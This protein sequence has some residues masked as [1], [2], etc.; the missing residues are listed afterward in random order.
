MAIAQ[1]GYI[2]HRQKLAERLTE[3][4]LGNDVMSSGG[5]S[6]LFMSAARR[7]GKSTFLKND[8]MPT[9]EGAGAV[10]VYVDLWTDRT[11]DPDDLIAAAIGEAMEKQAGLL[12]RVV[13][14]AT[15]TKKV[16]AQG[17][18]FGFKVDFGFERD[19][20]GKPGGTTLAKAFQAL[21]AK[22]KKQIVFII[23]EAQHALTTE[24][25]SDALFALKAA[26]DALNLTADK[27]QLAILATGSLRGKLMDLTRRKTQAFYGALVQDF[28]TLDDDYLQHLIKLKLGH[29]LAPEALPGP[30]ALMEAFTLVGKRPEEMEKVIALA[31]T[32]PQQDLG[33]AMQTVARLRRSELINDLRQQISGLSPLQRAILRLMF[34]RGEDFEAFTKASLAEYERMTDGQVTESQVQRALAWLVKEGLIWR[35]ARGA[36][37]VD[38]QMV[39]EYFYD[40]HVDEVLKDFDDLPPQL[41]EA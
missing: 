10:A 12:Q 36:Y 39:S 31:V 24:A 19:S 8:L 40:L 26:R 22:V 1:P 7:T 34:Q 27:P 4:L 2:F 14:A 6:G 28:P 32:H 38:D 25:G 9:L 17:E 15:G 30:K 18:A 21:H 11:R 3:V 5:R 29:R 35:S 37:A 20:I 16:A 23:D 13:S 33:L 41:P